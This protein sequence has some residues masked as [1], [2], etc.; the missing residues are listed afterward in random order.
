MSARSAKSTK[1]ARSA[2]SAKSASERLG[3]AEPQWA[4]W[5]EITAKCIPVIAQYLV[6]AAFHSAEPPPTRTDPSPQAGPQVG[7]QAGPHSPLY[8]H[9]DGSLASET[10]KTRVARETYAASLRALSEVSK[11]AYAAVLSAFSLERARRRC[12]GGIRLRAW[13]ASLASHVAFTV[14][15]LE[16]YAHGKCLLCGKRKADIQKR[17]M[18]LLV[19][20]P[21]CVHVLK[22]RGTFVSR[23]HAISALGKRRRDAATASASSASSASAASAQPFLSANPDPSDKPANTAN[24]DKHGTLDGCLEL[25]ATCPYRSYRCVLGAPFAAFELT[26]VMP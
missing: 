7:P 22:Q 18:P 14:R 17:M 10:R 23:A 2:K 12:E 15:T 1:S 11:G 24:T 26:S 5:P 16:A 9:R 3:R 8:S 21:T 6:R 19:A 25:V 20:H 13:P 4:G